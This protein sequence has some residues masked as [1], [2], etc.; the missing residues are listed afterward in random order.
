MISKEETQSKVEAIQIY[1]YEKETEADNNV[2]DTKIYRNRKL[3][4]SATLISSSLL[5]INHSQ[6]TV[7]LPTRKGT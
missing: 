6:S 2:Y 7:I 3:K 4:S 1:E 5:K